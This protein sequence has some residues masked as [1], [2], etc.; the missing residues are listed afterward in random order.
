VSVGGATHN[1]VFVATMHDSLFAF[2]ADASPCTSLW[3]V[4]LIDAT[5]GGTSGETSVPNTLVGSGYGDIAPEIGVIGTPVIDL[6]SGILYV[7]SKS[8]NSAQTT[9]Y[10]RLH[11][12]DMT[13]GNEKTGSPVLIAGTYPGIGDGGTTVAFNAKQENQ[14]GGLALL[15]GVVYITWAAH[16]DK[17]PWYGWIMG[18]HYTGSALTQTAALNVAPDFQESGIWMSGGA[19]AA[20][21]NN[22]LYVLT[23]NGT[24]NASNAAPPNTD[25]GDS[26][27]QLSS[28]LAVN[29]YF[30]PSDQ[31]S[32]QQNDKDFG[33]GGSAVLAD[34]PAGNVVTHVL[35]CGGKD[36]T[37]YVINRDLLGG[38]GDSAAVQQPPINL[39]HGIF[40]TTA[41]WNN[42]VYVGAAGSP[43]TA[44]K[45]NT[46]TVQ[47]SL[48]SSSSA[49]YG[50][51]G[52]TP[53]VS[54][55]GAT[56]NGLVWALN[57]N[58]Y[59]TNQSSS[60]GSA[61]LH[62]YDATNLATEL[63]NSSMKPADAAGNAVK[64]SVPTV[65]NGKVYVGTR[66]NNT[67]G[68]DN[69]TS[70]PGELDIYGLT[71]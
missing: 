18:Y 64:F 71:Q 62:V 59:C 36:G 58:S 13:T 4:S 28:A 26:L 49:T 17:A 68:A 24:F 6:S 61:V 43:L 52:S 3:S 63:W 39:G 29:Q 42:S 5:H 9:F 30:T 50:W 65:A 41:I 51:P 32:D 10:Q 8:V 20:D 37:L 56:Q 25:Y 27:L 12:I 23:G 44:Y 47:L 40:S 53:S 31:L 22:N 46:S 14:R 19:P 1:V 34:L 15:N 69:S 33:A 54:S 2:D 60:C 11:A 21:S 35:I 66:G 67:G 45:I 57:T 38:F 70:T 48:G 55:R 16:E 7:V